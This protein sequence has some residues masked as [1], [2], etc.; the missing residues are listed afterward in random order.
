MCCGM[1]LRR[2]HPH[3]VLLHTADKVVRRM[4]CCILP[5]PCVH[6][7]VHKMLQLD[8]MRSCCEPDA[9]HRMHLSPDLVTH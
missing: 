6:D 9:W 7:C 3:T 2:H 1:L 5:T 8:F 4:G